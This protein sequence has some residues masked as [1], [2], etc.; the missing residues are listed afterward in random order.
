MVG[1]T[2]KWK[3]VLVTVHNYFPYV[4][5]EYTG[6]MEIESRDEIDEYLGRLKD[7]IEKEPTLARKGGLITRMKVCKKMPFY[8]YHPKK[9]V[10]VKIYYCLPWKREALMKCLHSGRILSRIG[11]IFKL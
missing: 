8:G 2:D 7:A 6:P 4:Y 9:R 10:F 3:K 5:I 11:F 1:M